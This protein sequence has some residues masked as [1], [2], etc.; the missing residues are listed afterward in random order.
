M[1]N[2]MIDFI[3]SLDAYGT[4]NDWPGYWGLEGPEYLAWLAEDGEIPQTMLMGAVTYREMA[5]YAE[6]MPD[7]PGL[8]AMTSMPKVVFSSTLETPLSWDNT[9]LVGGDA[10]E[11]V[12]EMKEGDSRELR[13]VGSISLCRALLEA[14]LVDRLRVVIFPV[15]TGASG[16][17]RLFEG[18]PDMKLDLVEKRTFDGRLQLLEY[19]PTVLDEPPG[20]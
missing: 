12:K 10:A 11:A 13:T 15:V 9:E 8:A 20:A 2:L 7:E 1:A 16:R 6:A 5:G 4:A 19:V 3:S 14:R 17:D 18:Y